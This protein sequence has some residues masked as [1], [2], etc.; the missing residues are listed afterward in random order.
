MCLVKTGQL[1]RLAAM[2]SPR[3]LR[4]LRPLVLLVG[5][6]HCPDITAAKELLAALGDRQVP[7][8]IRKLYS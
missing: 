4:P 8:M 5:W 1:D 7:L 2:L 6:D 3:E